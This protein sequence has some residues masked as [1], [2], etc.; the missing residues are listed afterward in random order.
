MTTFDT[1]LAVLAGLLAM[2]IAT[3]MVV[4]YD[5]RQARQRGWR[6]SEDTLL[7]MA[8]LGGLAGAFLG[9]AHFRHKTRNQPFTGMLWGIALVEAAAG[10]WLAGVVAV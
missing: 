1:T 2:N 8:A 7:M 3:F 4:G 6:V 9:R 10:W 5:K